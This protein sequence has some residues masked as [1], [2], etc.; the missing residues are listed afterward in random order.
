MYSGA[1]SEA[2]TYFAKLGHECPRS[3]NPPDFLMD[4]LVHQ[5]LDQNARDQIEADFAVAP[6]TAADYPTSA[7]S[8]N[9]ADPGEGEEEMEQKK[10]KSKLRTNAKQQSFVKE[11]VSLRYAVPYHEQLYSM[12]NS[13]LTGTLTN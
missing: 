10:S 12:S 1:S 13:A 9:P 6:L 11:H 5:K 7:V 4:L 2:T 3:Y 8:E